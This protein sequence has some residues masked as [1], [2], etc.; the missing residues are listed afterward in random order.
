MPAPL[1]A[2]LP[3]IV[4]LISVAAPEVARAPPLVAEF[5]VNS[6]RS[7]VSVPPLLRAPP[8]SPPGVLPVTLPPLVRC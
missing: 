8:P 6:E 1:V 2:A 4:V 7:I 3:E 5:S